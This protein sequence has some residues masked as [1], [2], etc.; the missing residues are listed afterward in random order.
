MLHTRKVRTSFFVVSIHARYDDEK[1][2]GGTDD[3]NEDVSRMTDATDVACP[4][5]EWST[6]KGSKT[7]SDHPSP[8]DMSP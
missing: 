7:D 2:R 8:R 3:S 5:R 1:G 6:S 4:K